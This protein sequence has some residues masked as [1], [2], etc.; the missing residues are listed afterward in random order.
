MIERIQ[1]ALRQ[2]GISLWRIN[3]AV[4][5]TAEL[6]FVRQKLDTRRIKDVRKYEV[7]V[8]RDV[9]G[10]GGEKR[11]G[12]TAVPLTAAMDDGQIAE[13]LR[14]AYYAAQFAANPFYELAD[15]VKGPDRKSVV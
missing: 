2:C 7:S 11:R 1:N 3:E 8:F 12:F 5:E 6:F 9:D 14:S 15:P 4:E 10:D 13:E